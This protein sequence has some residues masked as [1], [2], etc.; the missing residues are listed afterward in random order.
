MARW[1]LT[2]A[3]T[4]TAAAALFIAPRLSALVSGPTPTPVTP[5]DVPPEPAVPLGAL[6]VEAGLDRLQVLGQGEER[7]LVITVDAPER[8][9]DTIDRPVDLAV[10]LDASGSMSDRGKIDYARQAAKLLANSLDAD[11]RFS[12]ITFNDSARTLIPAMPVR[13]HHALERAI[14]GIF[15]GGGTNLFAGLEQGG[16]QVLNSVQPGMVG[17]VVVLSDGHANVGLTTPSAFAKLS[18]DLSAG[19][20][21]V[22]AIGLGRDY[23]EDLLAQMADIGGG[24]YDWVDD[25]R[26]LPVVLADELERTA[27]VV[28]RGVQVNVQLPPNVQPL[29]VLG[30]DARQVDG[31]WNVWLGDVYAGETRKIVARVRVQGNEPGAFQA[32][33]VQ[34][35]Y[36]DLL[37]DGPARTTAVANATLT[38]DRAAAAASMDRTRSLASQEAWGAWHLEQSTRAWEAGDR[39]E[40]LRANREGRAVLHQAAVD[41]EDE[42]LE[43]SVQQLQA[44]GYVMETSSPHTYEGKGALKAA[45]E[46]S[47]ALAR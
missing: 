1:H 3:L 20:V 26:N 35:D 9:G 32:A 38:R 15:Y 42:E 30:W 40:A 22:S 21:A 46:E 33:T 18:S 8:G 27:S 37:L 39:D 4:A 13:D 7:F 5:I 14:D 47:R 19:G 24:T 31:G 45:K 16:D 34:A 6:R 44:L 12:L 17:R 29:D 28:A 43:A 25:P 2:L 10:V 23:N 36:L 41:F 11:D